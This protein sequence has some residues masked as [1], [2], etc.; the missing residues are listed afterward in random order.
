MTIRT[1]CILMLAVSAFVS[2]ACGGESAKTEGTSSSAVPFDRAF[3][4]GMVPH[5]ESAVKMAK[6]AQANGLSQPEL[7]QI[8]N[9]IIA[10]QQLEID[11]MLSW[12][13]RWFGSSIVDPE[14]AAELGL[15]EVDMGMQHEAADFE[16][17]EDVDQAFA[18]MMIDHHR[19]AV[20]MAQLALD[21]GQHDEIKQLARVIISA[22]EREIKIMEPHAGGEHHG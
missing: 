13:E 5:H 21:N 9:N 18:A 1:L 16:N 4:D 14:G 12:R 15:S 20:R 22:Q 10:T 19:G 3:I 17:V 7:N 2:T 8:A 6:A 11:D